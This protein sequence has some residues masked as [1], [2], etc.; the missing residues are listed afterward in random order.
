M[1]DTDRRIRSIVI[2]GGGSAGWMTAAALANTTRGGCRIEVIESTAIGTV[3]MGLL[4]RLSATSTRVE[5]GIYMAVLGF[6]IGLVMQIL[7]LVVQNAAPREQC[8]ARPT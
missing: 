7:V 5:N 6:G 2:L 1:S 3:G 4:S 8:T